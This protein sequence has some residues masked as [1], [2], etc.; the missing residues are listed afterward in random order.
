MKQG[1]VV[2][3]EFLVEKLCSWDEELGSNAIEVYV[4]R[5]RKKLEPHGI[6]VS[7]V[8]GLGY[9]LERQAV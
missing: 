4:H 5:L 6:M 9:M 7:T 1:K 8:R 3:K 2:T